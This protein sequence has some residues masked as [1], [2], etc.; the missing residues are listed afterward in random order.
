[1]LIKT[2]LEINIIYKVEFKLSIFY[3]NVKKE[4]KAT[5]DSLTAND[6]IG[7]LAMEYSIPSLESFLLLNSLKTRELLSAFVRSCL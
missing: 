1:L 3:R 6:S 2:Y 7:I 5:Y 4:V